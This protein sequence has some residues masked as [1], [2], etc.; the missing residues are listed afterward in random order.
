MTNTVQ[1]M[2]EMSDDNYQEE[3]K[4]VLSSKGEYTLSKYQALVLKQEIAKGN[5]ATV[6]FDTFAIAIPYVVEF[7]RVKKFLE[8]EFQLPA[9]ASEKPY[10]PIP[11]EKWEEIKKEVYEKIGKI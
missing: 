7:Y 1:S 4:V 6:M 5:R 3:W 11:D 2:P 10:I 8:G 9:T